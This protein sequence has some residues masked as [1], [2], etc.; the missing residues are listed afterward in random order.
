MIAESETIQSA[1]QSHEPLVLTARDLSKTYIH[2]DR[3]LTAI[4][5]INLA[6]GRAEIVAIVGPSGCGKTTLLKL[7][8]RL[9]QPTTGTITWQNAKPPRSSFV[10]QKPLL[11]PW[12]TVE[13]NIVLPFEIRRGANAKTAL[14]RSRALLDVLG[15]R[16][17]AAAYPNELSGGMAQRASIARALVDEPDI[18]FLDEP[19]SAVDEI[20]RE[21][22]WSDFRE[23]WNERHVPAVWVTHNVREAVFLADRVL[24]MS[25]APGTI[26]IEVSITLPKARDEKILFSQEFIALTKRI[27]D[28]LENSK[29]K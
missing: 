1:S 15:L 2:P 18:L 6:I 29:T 14:D 11:L 13:Q 27:R 26:K 7:L 23:L 8:A 12:R 25:A 22:L 5:H 4:E 9:S 10:F 28:A 16:E 19:L 3:R 21:G 24:V 20:R 17:F